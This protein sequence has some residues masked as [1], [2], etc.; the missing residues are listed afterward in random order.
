MNKEN[1][2]PTN[3]RKMAQRK[4]CKTRNLVQRLTVK[5]GSVYHAP[6][7]TVSMMGPEHTGMDE[8]VKKYEEYLSVL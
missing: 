7:A 2:D 3:R 5:R 1:Q 8:K 4:K 6:V